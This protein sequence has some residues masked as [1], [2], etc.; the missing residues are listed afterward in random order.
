[1]PQQAIADGPAEIVKGIKQL[2][3]LPITA[4]R[5][6]DMLRGEE[7][8]LATVAELIE[9]DPVVTAAVLRHASSIRLATPCMPT[10]REAVFRLGTFA[11]LD[12]VLEGYL[13]K[14]SVSTPIYQLS[15]RDLWLHGAASKLAAR[16]LAAECPRAKIPSI[17][18]TAALLH[19]VGKLLISRCLKA[20]V[21][22]LAEHARA[23]ALTFL[24]AERELL[25][26]DHAAVGAAMAV[27]W[28]FPPEVSDAIRRH[29]SPPFSNSCAV[30]DAVCLANVVAKTIE[31][32]LGADGLNFAVDPLSY[33]RLGVDYPTFGRVCLQTD[34]A[35]RDAISA[36]GV[37]L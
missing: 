28:R 13:K 12:L 17:A 4:Q 10:V 11:L 23:K 2:E 18:E 3:P 35:L 27:A 19:D 24:E 33:R 25:G 21:R 30:L 31:A 1:M 8:A 16:T 14:L 37:T 32:G 29:H 5:L 36:H 6:L 15:E 34:A 7:V 9:L 22:D 26:T 20:D